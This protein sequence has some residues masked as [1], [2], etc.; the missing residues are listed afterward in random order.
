MKWQIKNKF[1]IL[2][3]TKIVSQYKLP[4]RKTSTKVLKLSNKNGKFKNK[5]TSKY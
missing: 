2:I 3:K 4:Q 5:I 1:K